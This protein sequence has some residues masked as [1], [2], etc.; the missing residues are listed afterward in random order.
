M[1]FTKNKKILLIGK[2][3]FNGLRIKYKPFVIINFYKE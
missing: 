3:L 1:Q 2:G